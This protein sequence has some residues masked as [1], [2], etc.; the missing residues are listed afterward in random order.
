MDV[1]SRPEYLRLGDFDADGRLDIAVVESERDVASVFLNQGNR[2]F[3]RQDPFAV[4]AG[5]EWISA[6]LLDRDG[7]PDLIV[8]GLGGQIGVTPYDRG[9]IALSLTSNQDL[10]GLDFGVILP[11]T[12]NSFASAKVLSVS[13]FD[14]NLDGH[15]TPLDALWIINRLGR[16]R[17][18]IDCGRCDVNADGVISPLDALLVINRLSLNR[19]PVTRTPPTSNT[20]VQRERDD[21]DPIVASFM[22]DALDST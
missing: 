8:L 16:S 17:E 18:A 1:G 4:P 11:G 22:D 2:R 6:G 10:S 15:V 14:T 9:S 12:T 7:N 5:A 3:A 20:Q 19:M 13:V 21:W